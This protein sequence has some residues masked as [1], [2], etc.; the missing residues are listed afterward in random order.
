M[1]QHI[2]IPI[3]QMQ[4]GS[5][6]KTPIYE[7]VDK[8]EVL[9]L[10]AGTLVTEALISKLKM[11]G[12]ESVRV[13]KRD[14]DAVNEPAKKKKSK[15]DNDRRNGR[16]FGITAD[17]FLH[18]VKQHG[19]TG[20]DK[21]TV[22]RFQNNFQQAAEQTKGMFDNLSAGE[23]VDGNAILGMS[24][25]A[26]S[27]L[28]EDMDLFLS[29]G[30]AE[31]ADEYPYQHSLQTSMVASSIG[32]VMG[33]EE[34]EM[35]ELGIGCMVH[36]IGMLKLPRELYDTSHVLT[37]IEFLEITKHPKYTFEIIKEVKELPIGARMIAYQMHERW[38][39]SGYPRQ[40]EGNNIHPLARIAAVADVFV[41]LINPRAHR[42]AILPYY[43]VEEI[44]REAKNGL[45]D[46][47][48]V[49]GLLHTV[50]LFPVGSFIEVND[51][52]IGK[53]VRS[54]RERYTQPVIELWS[55]DKV[56]GD[57]E[58][59]DLFKDRKVKIVRPLSS[60]ALPTE[61]LSDEATVETKSQVS[62][63]VG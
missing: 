44:I 49:R 5:Q 54:N 29:M 4:L 32:A 55:A 47:E 46:P 34:D 22:D 35:R 19:S 33:L 30:V 48:A 52:R 31:T 3:N 62:Q 50:S 8:R 21:E 37:D 40:R 43:A 25:D 63:L 18:K 23:S 26:L 36:D 7:D 16:S 2:S 12:V 53:V 1:S 42:P 15:V 10:P 51:G 56:E 41:A 9:L 28:T 60:L 13:R 6:L 17:S 24:S 20:Y 57:G 39:G 45:F 38:N 11:R 14:L 27:Q 59:V 58:V 61:E